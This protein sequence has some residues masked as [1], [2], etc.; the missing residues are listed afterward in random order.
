MQSSLMGPAD[1][2]GLVLAVQACLAQD[3]DQQRGRP[4]WTWPTALLMIPEGAVA[5]L[6]GH[7][8]LAAAYH[9]LLL[10]IDAAQLVD[11]LAGHIL[12]P[13]RSA[14]WPA[15]PPRI[16]RQLAEYR[17]GR[18]V[19]HSSPSSRW[20]RP[21]WF[22]DAAV[23]DAPVWMRSTNLVL[24]G[25]RCVRVVTGRHRYRDRDDHREREHTDPPATLQA[26]PD[27]PGG[28]NCSGGCSPENAP[29]G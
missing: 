28:R 15:E 22:D 8:F 25:G 4:D 3:D 7:Q 20:C 27:F 10:E 13:H 14:R 19:M 17:C 26:G 1:H 29:S 11:D 16:H 6:V 2:F 12:P 24:P 21:G 18:T 9:R 23:V 5:R